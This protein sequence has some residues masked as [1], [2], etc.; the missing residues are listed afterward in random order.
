[1]PEL[2]ID[3]RPYSQAILRFDLDWSTKLETLGHQL[4][5][6]LPDIQLDTVKLLG[7]GGKALRVTRT[8]GTLASSGL[9]VSGPLRFKLLGSLKGDVNAVLQAQDAPAIASFEHEEHR[10][11][12]RQAAPDDTHRASP[13]TF[14]R[15]QAWQ[16]PDLVPPPSEALKL[17]QRLASD[18]GILKCMKKHGWKVGML[19]EMP[20][21]GKVGLSPV[22]VLGVNKN[23][24]QEISLR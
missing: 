3:A 18:A 20:P 9:A 6:A 16:Y 10:A 5:E 22:C 8:D 11:R 23:Q 15:Y 1:M 12:S 14:G 19:S 24:G 4:E 2:I 7:K 13:D 21:A 17:L